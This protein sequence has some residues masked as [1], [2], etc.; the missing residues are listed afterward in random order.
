[1]IKHIHDE[2]EKLFKNT[3]YE[4]SWY[5]YHD[6]LTLKTA[7]ATVTWMKN[8]GIYKRWLL[9]LDINVGTVYEERLVGNSPKMI[10]LYN[11][12]NKDHDDEVRFHI[13]LTS[14]LNNDDPKKFSLSTPKRGSSAYH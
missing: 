7:K 12:L 3:K 4:D 9:P 2:S 13:L 5:Y 11:T 6:A 10:P 8:N 1:M 14:H